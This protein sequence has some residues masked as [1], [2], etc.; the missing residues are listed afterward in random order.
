MG[1]A[2]SVL[3]HG[4]VRCGEVWCVVVWCGILWYGMVLKCDEVN[5]G[6]DSAVCI[7]S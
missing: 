1:G 2:L 5:S 3:W 6:I 7:R 4:V